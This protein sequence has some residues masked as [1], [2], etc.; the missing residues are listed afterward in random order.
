MTRVLAISLCI[1]SLLFCGALFVIYH[2][3]NIIESQNSKIDNLT[4]NVEVLINGRKNDY[5]NKVELA[6]RN[7]ELEQAAK[8]DTACFT[9]NTDISNHA[10]TIELRKDRG[11]VR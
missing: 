8:K 7:E 11:K 10:L 5:E 2:R 4:A 1:V 3:G 9:W 6:K